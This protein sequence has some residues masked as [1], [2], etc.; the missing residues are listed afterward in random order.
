MRQRKQLAS[1]K[2]LM[3]PDTSKAKLT[4][5]KKTRNRLEVSLQEMCSKYRTGFRQINLECDLES[6]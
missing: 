6:A 4:V 2:Y 5:H 1:S 3:D